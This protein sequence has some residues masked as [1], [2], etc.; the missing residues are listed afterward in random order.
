MT[1][2]P[3]GKGKPTLSLCMIVKNE[4][5][6]LE[7]CLETARPYVDEIVVIDTGSTDATPDIARRYADHFEQ[8]EWPDSFAAARNHSFD[9]G[10]GDY[11]MYLDGDEY[12]PEAAQWKE[13]RR[14]L[15]QPRVAAVEVPIRN[16]L[17]EGQLMQSDRV[18]QTRVFRNSPKLRFQG[19]VHNQIQEA[20]VAY[21]KLTGEKIVRVE[22][23]IIHT[24][25][26]LSPAKM[27]EKYRPRLH[28]LRAEYEQPISQLYKAY[29]GYQLGVV[30]FVLGQNEEAEQIFSELDYSLLTP[31]NAFYTHL[32]ASHTAL[33]LN[34]YQVALAHCDAMLALDQN[35]P[36]AYYTTGIS[37]L[38]AGRL[39]D[40]LLMLLEA[41]NVNDRAGAT[42]RFMLNPN[43]LLHTLSLACESAGLKDHATAFRVLHEKG[44]SNLKLVRTLISTLQTGIVVAEA[45]AAGN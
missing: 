42:V 5:A 16:L 35:E 45:E 22:A 20:L 11:I 26:A 17:S 27:K 14:I 21:V 34:H 25:Y 38:K 15:G 6:T 3:P 19:R 30:L 37:F 2:E 39:G 4:A 29:Y 8:I 31:Q 13:L 18:W 28:L 9:R 24:G 1:S 44:I 36:I 40:G 33:K 23:E 7:R 43:T 10:T 41:F 32:L 12:I